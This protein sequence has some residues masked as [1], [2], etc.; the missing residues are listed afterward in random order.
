MTDTAKAWPTPPDLLIGAVTLR[1]LRLEDWTLEQALSRDPDV[2]RWTYYPVDLDDEQALGRISRTHER[3]GLVRRYSIRDTDDEPWGTCGLGRLDT[4]VPEVFYALLPGGRGRGAA[5]EAARLLTEWT[6][7]SG[8]PAVA[9]LTIEG[10]QAS[11][12]VARRIGFELVDEQEGDLRGRPVT[13]R[14]W[15]RSA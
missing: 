15:V 8:R 14:R 3:S 11:E 4:E 7:G 6:L 1:A 12:R 13:M 10:N 2:V 5:T 9:L